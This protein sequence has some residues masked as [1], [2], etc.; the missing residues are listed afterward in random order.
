[1]PYANRL[2]RHERGSLR[3]KFRGGDT[4]L[5]LAL[6]ELTDDLAHECLIRIG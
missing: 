5:Q 1:M 2:L 4:G 3:G 6:I